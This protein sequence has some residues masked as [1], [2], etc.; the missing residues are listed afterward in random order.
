MP[1]SFE[2]P[3]ATTTA[4]GVTTLFT[5]SFTVLDK[6]D[7]A[8]K[9]ELSG[10]V[11]YPVDG[12]DYTV[13][14]IGSSTGSITFASPPANGTK[15]TRY[16]E[17]SLERTTDYQENGDLLARVLDDDFDRVWMALQDQLL[18]ASRA[19]RAP[20]G[21]SLQQLPAA[22]ERAL[23]A[24][25]FDAAG[26]PIAINRTDDGGTAL[27]LD[28]LDTAP[29]KGAALIGGFIGD[30]VTLN[31]PAQYA[32]IQAAFAYLSTKT[33]AR[34]ATVTIQ[35]AD[36]TYTLGST[37]N[38][39]HPQGS[40]IR[41][42][43]NVTTPTNCVI[44]VS[45][46]PTFDALYVDGGNTLGYLDGFKF[47]LAGK[48]G[49]TNNFTAVLANNG[50]TII[51]GPQITVNNWYYGI[52]ARNGS[53]VYCRYA[54]VSNS[55]DV[56]IWSMNG[57]SVDAQYASSA[58][59]VDGTSLGF[60]FQ[61]EYGSFL[62]A[63]NASASGCK[64][65]GIAALSGSTVRALAS[66]SSTN[67]GSGFFARDNGEIEC[68]GATANNNTRY[69]V[70]EYTTGVVYYSSITATGNTIAARAPSAA[71]DN[72]TLGARVVSSSGDLRVDTAGAN[73]IY[74]NTSGGPQAQIAHTANAVNYPKLTGTAGTK[75]VFTA[76]GTGIDLDVSLQGKGT[77]YVFLGDNKQNYLRVNANASGT[78][79][80]LRAEGVDTDIDLFL[81][82]KGAGLVR[83]GTY[84]SSADVACNG[85]ITIKD[86]AGTTRK[87]MTTA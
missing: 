62:D 65:A 76:N 1:I 69:G 24:L 31:V 60:G 77:G 28:L 68:H 34:G 59:A 8:V 21:E 43:G 37:V 58:G 15:V 67:T 32:T 10:V 49:I 3:I 80:Q 12:V 78:A 2:T 35:V 40:Q 81:G 55:G 53:F 85:Y 84:A 5:H 27:A 29:G 39:N 9:T 4:N 42:V 16:R 86:E 6:A 45:G 33:I 75:V 20:L 44:T 11:S 50:G 54:N 56:G 57:S 73:N 38:A 25:A 18:L 66:T 51:C 83:F 14:G 26:Q 19:L 71:F 46:A 13:A 79:P 61:A 23:K 17:V 72:T 22:S 7:L 52:A 36:G 82:G 70:E 74:F 41:L 47:D 63:S 30:S 64:I 48:A 87:L